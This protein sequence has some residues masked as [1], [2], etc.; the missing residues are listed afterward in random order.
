MRPVIEVEL[1]NGG[2]RALYLAHVIGLLVD[3]DVSA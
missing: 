3:G 1:V 2:G